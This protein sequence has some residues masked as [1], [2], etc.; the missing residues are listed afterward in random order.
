MVLKY[1]SETYIKVRYSELERFIKE[2]C[3]KEVEIAALE[4]CRNGDKLQ[5]TVPCGWVCEPVVAKAEACLYGLE[6]APTNL[7]HLLYVLHKNGA[8]P[9]GN[10]LIDVSW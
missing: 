6:K 10:Y 7:S 4:E 5:L 2:V 1:T 9:A 3:G 8:I